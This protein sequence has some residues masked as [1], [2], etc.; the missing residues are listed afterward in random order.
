MRS[1]RTTTKSS[2]RS[3]QLEKAHAHSNEDPM[4]PK[5][6]PKTTPK[7]HT[8]T[9]TH[10]HIPLLQLPPPLTLALPPEQ[11]PTAWSPTADKGE[12]GAESSPGLGL[13]RAPIPLQR[14]PRPLGT[15]TRP[16]G[17][18]VSATSGL[19]GRQAHGAT[20]RPLLPPQL[21][22]RR[23]SPNAGRAGFQPQLFVL[24]PLFR[25]TSVD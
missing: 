9:H 22:P 3:R 25:G 8:H 7:T 19:A 17:Q 10:T 1:P 13:P 12:E 5:K 16:P 23:P 2:P 14:P 11:D 15:A 18:Q 20:W 21:L 24:C 4:H 6:N